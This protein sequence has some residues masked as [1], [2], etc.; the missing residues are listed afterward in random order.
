MFFQLLVNPVG[1]KIFFEHLLLLDYMQLQILE[2]INE[3]LL[4]GRSFI[5][6]CL[7]G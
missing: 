7:F 5:F 2:Q 1:P 3:I 6:A 4:E